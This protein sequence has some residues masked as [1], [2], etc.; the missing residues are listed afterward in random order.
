[1]PSLFLPT[2]FVSNKLEIY[3]QAP[4]TTPAT[5]IHRINASIGFLTFVLNF[6]LPLYKTDLIALSVLL[7]LLAIWFIVRS[8]SYFRIKISFS[9]SSSFSTIALKLMVASK[10]LITS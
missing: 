2:L 8:S 3:I 10:L 6:C 4:I 1:M 7:S 9:S 5:S